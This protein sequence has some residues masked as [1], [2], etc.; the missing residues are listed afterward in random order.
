MNRLLTSLNTQRVRK[1]V[2]WGMGLIL[3]YVILGFFILPPILR[4]VAVRQLTQQLNRPTSIQQV[5]INPLTLSLTVKGL[6]VKERNDQPFV[7]WDELYAN[8]QLSSL[9]RWTWTFDEIQLREPRIRIV[10]EE[11]GRF[12]FADLLAGNTN[13]PP[14]KTAS[15]EGLPR[16][17]VF[18]LAITNGHFGFEDLSR[19]RPFRSSYE[20]FHIHLTRFTTRRDRSS[21][22]SFAASS[23]LGGRLAWEG[24]ITAHPPASR[25]A[26][27]MEGIQLTNYTPL[28]EEFTRAQLAEGRLDVEGGY[29]FA[30]TTNGLDLVVSN[31]AVKTTELRLQDADPGETVLALAGCELRGGQLDWRARQARA[32]SLLVNAPRVVARRRADGSINLLSLALPHSPGETAPSHSPSDITPASPPWIIALDDFR[33]EGG[34]AEWEDAAVAPPFRT[35]LQP[36]RLR[37]E[38]FTTAPE[39][40]AA[41]RA[42]LLT[43][44]VEGMELAAVYTLTPPRASGRLKLAG[45]ELKKYQPY[46]APFFRGRIASGKT[47]AAL[48]FSLRRGTGANEMIVSNGVVRLSNLQIQPPQGNETWIQLPNLSVENA[49]ASL[50]ERLVRVGALKSAGA[51]ILAR[52]ETNGAINLLS[53]LATNQ[54][55]PEP[56]SRPSMSAALNPGAVNDLRPAPEPSAGTSAFPASAGW[57]AVLE[58]LALKDYAVRLEDQ[59]LPAPGALTVDQLALHLRDFQFP[60][61]APVQVDGAARLNEAGAITVG[62]SMRPYHPSADLKVELA[63]LEMSKFQPWIE[64]Q[65]KL[66]L[67]RGALHLKG[68]LKLD[69]LGGAGPWLRW[70]GDVAITHL[71][72]TDR[73]LFKELA[74][75]EEFAINGLHLSIGPNQLSARQARFVGLRSS[76]ILGPD[77]RPTFLAIWPD[78]SGTNAATGA[79]PEAASAPKPAATPAPSVEDSFPIQIEELVFEKAALHF[80]DQSIQPPCAFDVRQFSGAIQGLSSQPDSTANIDVSGMVDQSSPFGLR[81]RINPLASPL[82]LH[83]TFTNHNLQLTPFTPYMEKFGGYPLNKGRLSLALEYTL[84]DQA[85]QA[86]NKVSIDQLMLG[87][88]NNSPDAVQLPVK[89]A[90]ALLKDNQGRIELD[91]PVQGRLDD[92]QFRI[93]PI[94]FKVLANLIVKTA[95]SPFKLLGS[96]VGGGEEMSY[97]EFAP[98]SAFLA[99]SETN[100]LNKLIGALE[101]RPALSLEI[102]G[103]VDPVA[104]R[105]ELARRL[106]REHLKSLRL[107]EISNI[108]QI[109]PREEA[110]QIDPADSERLL[111][112]RLIETFSASLAEAIRTLAAPEAG[113]N[114]LGASRSA[115]Q[116]PSL[117]KRWL[118]IFKPRQERAAILQAHRHL[119]ADE[120]LLQEHPELAGLT[121]ADMELLLARKTE[122][123]PDNLRPLM[124]ERAKAV[125]AYLLNS[126]KITADR[127][128]LVTPKTPDASFKGERRAILTLN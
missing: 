10:L 50:G 5:R 15:E 53:L 37:L 125:Q 11:N 109:L 64:R 83:L 14:P 43:E 81:G 80:E 51:S 34:M 41:L 36:I 121:I 18:N 20:P 45:V 84:R 92:P 71:L 58:E 52:R 44:A 22:Y 127:L 56:A 88:R 108:G 113:T 57:R 8:F 85:L 119:K 118:S 48:E 97:V 27:R 7:S 47:D 6:A 65:M 26:L 1:R 103:S 2:A 42:S 66:A 46:L 17:L 105:D 28:L 104:D 100:K 76:V 4:A 98:G 25:G 62:G 77:Q 101:K 128:F 93:A 16:L 102:E 54:P 61:N 115:A 69:A 114:Q 35:T 123:P 75:W 122:V 112:A 120:M 82:L 23:E 89:L 9:F 67:N 3:L 29:H 70:D 91:L 31:L 38:H 90:V 74:G 86:E 78:A 126:G 12:N 39:R 13:D 117:L 68:R 55:S 59:Q 63:N 96:L 95:A 72:A 32:G 110:F 107:K 49:S 73:V 19:R 30:W 21:P 94:L 111:R 33:I 124:Q 79:R 87:P 116:N 99:D 106:V 24:Q 40:E 60:S